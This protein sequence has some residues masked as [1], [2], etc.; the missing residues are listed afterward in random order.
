MTRRDDGWDD[1]G[2]NRKA[3]ASN[4]TILAREAGHLPLLAPVSVGMA[5]DAI[6]RRDAEIE[7]LRAALQRHVC[8][9]VH[10]S[11]IETHAGCHA[12]YT[13]ENNG[14]DDDEA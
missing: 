4:L 5:F 12:K 2:R 14:V 1:G 6:D 7:R 8:Q 13:L 11:D 9:H 10:C 3:F